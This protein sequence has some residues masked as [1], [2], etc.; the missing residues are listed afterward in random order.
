MKVC[1]NNIGR[2]YIQMKKRIGVLLIAVMCVFSII[3]CNKSVE[4]SE[5]EPEVVIEEE[6]KYTF[7]FSCITMDN[8]YF[9]ALEASLREQIETEGH[10]LITKDAESDATLQ[11]EQ[12]DELIAQ[13]ID[14]VFLAPVDWIEI[15]PA[16]DRLNEAGIKV[17]NLDTQVQAFDKVDAYVGSDNSNAGYLCGKDLLERIPQ[18]GKVIIVECPNRNS[19][20]ERIKGFEK[21]VAQKGF[22]VVARIDAKGDLDIALPEVETA[23]MEYPDVVAIMCGNDPMA[24]GSVVA[25]N[26]AGAK[27]LI[28]YGIDGSP[29]VKKEIAKEGSLVAATV[30][31]SP[32]TMGVEATN[33][34]LKMLNDEKYE[35]ITYID[36]FLINQE[37]VAEYGI[38]T[39]Q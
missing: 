38:D 23:L 24:I 29:D 22:E 31:Q 17:I 9:I 36:T 15:E 35:E 39:W 37:N 20:N 26:N 34:A 13:K 21:A 16:L 19:V 25:A 4:I 33:I 2:S 30:A 11:S 14:A 28:I 8:P 10:T 3:A 12:I 6:T 27:G 32:K 1:C 7:G 5:E 18:G